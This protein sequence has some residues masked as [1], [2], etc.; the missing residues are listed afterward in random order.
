MEKARELLEKQLDLQRQLNDLHG[1]DVT[2]QQ[3]RVQLEN[4]LASVDAQLAGLGAANADHL[5][6]AV[7]SASNLASEMGAVLDVAF[8]LSSAILGADNALTR[9]IGSASQVA[10]G[11]SSIIDITKN[12]QG[13]FS[14]IFSSAAT[15]TSALP[16][17]GQIIGG[18]LAIASTLSGLFSRKADPEAAAQRAAVQANTQA[19]KDL[20]QGLTTVNPLSIS[21]SKASA[22]ANTPFTKTT[23]Q[24]GELGGQIT[25]IVSNLTSKEIIANLRSVGVSLGDLKKAAEDLGIPLSNNPTP[26]ELKNLAAAIKEFGKIVFD[27]SAQGQLAEQDALSKLHGDDATKTLTDR[28]EKLKGI[29]P[30]V[31]DALAGIDTTTVEG[32]AEALKKLIA[33][34]DDIAAGKEGIDGG[35]LSMK[36]LFAEI[37]SAVTGLRG[38]DSKGATH[39]LDDY[40][41]RLDIFSQALDASGADAGQRLGKLDEFFKQ[42]FANVFKDVDVKAPIADVRAKFLTY[43]A[44]AAGDGNISEDEQAVIDA[45]K[46]IIAAIQAAGDEAKSATSA[47]DQAAADARAKIIENAKTGAQLTGANPD[48]ALAGLV[49][50]YAKALPK[51]GD[52]LA[53]ATTP[54]EIIARVTEIF[55]KLKDGSI[56]AESVGAPLEELVSDLLDLR[57]AAGDASNA[58]AGLA[59]KLSSAFDDIDVQ[60]Q[61]DGITDAATLLGK[62]LDAVG[63]KGSDLGSDAGR[64]STL[65]QLQALAAANPNDKALR[66]ILA[67]L[68]TSVRGLSPIVDAVAAGDAASGR[69][70]TNVRGGAVLTATIAQADVMI[71]LLTTILSVISQVRDLAKRLVEFSVATASVGGGSAA[72]ASAAIGASASGGSGG[73]VIT[74]YNAFN[75]Y[76]PVSAEDRSFARDNLTR[77]AEQ[78]DEALGDIQRAKFANAGLL[79]ASS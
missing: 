1:D 59:D 23:Q 8:G 66:Q 21:S 9:M 27:T 26:Q 60:A 5:A 33:L 76:G 67:Q 50:A 38:V 11:L 25:D 71:G 3:T 65:A 64:A 53:G 22:I 52:L 14:A 78:I 4:D 20:R 2:T 34:G 68:A 17:I 73:F 47:A 72:V 77:I 44:Q 58:I 51:L 49:A 42:E 18:G 36:D 70:E 28:I 7:T 12:L 48:A 55:A 41:K 43:I 16:G 10:H 69:G 75:F 79:R 56:T 24:Y 46:S 45:F 61:L 37:L 30:A 57:G 6:E 40:K 54:D 19:L 29:A 35:T 63:L 13:G 32:R 74:F 62:K 31:N 39:A 15:L